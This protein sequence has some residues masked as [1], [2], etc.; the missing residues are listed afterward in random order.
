ME[1]FTPVSSLAGG[2]LIGLAAALF[3]GLLGRICGV[4][5]ILG[6]LMAP[7]KGDWDWRLVFII[8]L[9]LGA[10]TA[11]GLDI[12]PREITLSPSLPLLIIGGLLVGLGT[13]I[14]SGCTS[15]HG[16]CG[17]SRFSLRSVV[18]TVIFMAVAVATVTAV[19]HF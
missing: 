5:G 10:L 19:R 9:V 1:G 6:G 16:V 15:G 4:S 14:G 7:T 18:A 12:A 11:R 17:M 8:G 13:T 2:L 3:M